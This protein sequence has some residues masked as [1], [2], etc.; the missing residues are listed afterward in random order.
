VAES[1]QRSHIVHYCAA[2]ARQIRKQTASVKRHAGAHPRIV[3]R[4][5]LP[6]VQ[7]FLQVRAAGGEPNSLAAQSTWAAT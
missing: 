2:K 3:F 5:F 4:Q 1:A 7:P 6:E